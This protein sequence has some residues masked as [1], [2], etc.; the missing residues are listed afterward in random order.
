MEKVGRRM[1]VGSLIWSLKTRYS[2]TVSM[3]ESIHFKM[4]SNGYCTPCF[5]WVLGGENDEH[6]GPCP[7]SQF[8]QGSEVT[9][10]N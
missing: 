6:Q 5:C 2:T 3:N 10:L 7:L 9:E 4:L 8:I 1:E